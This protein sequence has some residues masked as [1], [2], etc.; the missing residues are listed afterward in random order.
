MYKPDQLDW[1][2]IDLLNGNGRI[3]SAEIAR[4]LGDVSA[5]TVS[6]RIDALTEHG[7]INIRAVLNPKEVGYS[8]LADVFIQTQP[9]ELRSVIEQLDHLPQICYMACATG[10]TDIIIQVCAKNIGE[11]YDFVIEVLGKI[12]GVRQTRTYPI[13]LNVKKFS[14]WLPPNALEAEE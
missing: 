14:D 2:I 7:I 5:R 12:P 4:Q 1:K 8:V 6:N 3:S 11:L 13:H 9:S 10:D